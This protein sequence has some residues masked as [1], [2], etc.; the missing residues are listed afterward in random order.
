MRAPRRCW[1]RAD[2]G[3]RAPQART[4]G[5]G[6]PGGVYHLQDADGLAFDAI[7]DRVLTEY[8]LAGSLAPYAREGK[9]VGE[10]GEPHTGVAQFG[11]E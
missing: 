3:E 7:D 2:W 4:G 11:D 9:A 5:S 10:L 6:Q 1:R 8:A